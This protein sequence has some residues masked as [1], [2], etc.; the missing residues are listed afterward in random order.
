MISRGIRTKRLWQARQM[1]W[2][3]LRDELEQQYFDRLHERWNSLGWTGSNLREK[4]EQEVKKMPRHP[5][6]T[7]G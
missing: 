7:F 5:T 6:L 2:A 4:V 3:I 1:Q